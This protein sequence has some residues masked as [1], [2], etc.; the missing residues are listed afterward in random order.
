MLLRGRSPVARLLALT[1][2][3]GQESKTTLTKACRGLLRLLF[4]TSR[5]H[6]LGS[7][8]EGQL[9]PLIL[10]PSGQREHQ[11]G[12]P[13]GLPLVLGPVKGKESGVKNVNSRTDLRSG[14][15][16]LNNRDLDIC[17]PLLPSTG[18]HEMGRPMGKTIP[19][20]KESVQGRQRG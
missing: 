5:K 1:L 13:I 7:H 17:L 16:L 6:P 2:G 9:R 20:S 19:Y 14:I 10:Q 11:R 18:L 15:V 8:R 3:K 12:R 4:E